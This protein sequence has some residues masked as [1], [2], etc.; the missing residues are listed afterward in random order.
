[1]GR[2]H[3]PAI[4]GEETGVPS[5]A[6]QTAL[7]DNPLGVVAAGVGVSEEGRPGGAAMADARAQHLHHHFRLYPPLT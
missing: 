5:P 6:S 1:M 2:T 7:Q 4:V 3:L